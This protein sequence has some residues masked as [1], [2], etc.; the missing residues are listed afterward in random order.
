MYQKIKNEIQIF[1]TLLLAAVV[2]IFLSM[3]VGVSSGPQRGAAPTIEATASQGDEESFRDKMIRQFGILEG[4]IRAA[5]ANLSVN[6]TPAS[7]NAAPNGNVAF[8]V[9]IKNNGSSPVSNIFFESQF[10]NEFN[11]NNYVFS[12]GGDTATDGQTTWFLQGPIAANGTVTVTVNG[13]VDANS[14]NR[15]SAYVAQVYPLFEENNVKQDSSTL[16]V[17]NAQTC[18]DLYFPLLSKLP[19]PTPQ[20]IFYSEDFSDDDHEWPT[21]D[22][23]VDDDDEDECSARLQSGQYEVTVEEDETC[24]FPAPREAEKR[25]GTFEVDFQYDGDSDSDEF[26]AGIY[27]NGEGGDEFY[28]FRV[29]YEE[30]DCEYRL[31]R[32]D[33]SKANGG[34]D[35]PSN[36]YK[37]QNKL[38]ITRDTS[39][40]LTIFLNNT[41]LKTYKDGSPYNGKGTGVYVRETSKDGEI[42]IKFDNFKILN[43]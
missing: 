15:S 14:C 43:Q 19:T 25:I 41:Q 29:E 20:P 23:D 1:L 17:V 24:F 7:V 31:F 10:P 30:D 18:G 11:V 16:N 21:G 9:S 8:T 38:R 40:N 4:E 34:C 2:L 22:F 3:S 26:D 28:L 39:G 42:V 36:G 32:E 6:V 35:S 5:A 37:Q 13:T 12:G 27:I 33:D